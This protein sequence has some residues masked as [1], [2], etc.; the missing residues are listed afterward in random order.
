[1]GA[2]VAVA[3]SVCLAAA[4]QGGCAASSIPRPELPGGAPVELTDTSFHPQRDY[5]CGPAALA[6]VLESAGVAA[7]P[8]E[9]AP[10]LY[11]PGRRGSFQ[12]EMAALPR[13]YDRLAVPIEGSLDAVVDQLLRG[14]PVLVLQNLA[15]ERLPR[16]HYAV[17][18][19]Y[20]PEEDRFVLRSGDEQRMRVSRTRF[21]ATWLRAGRW[22][23]VVLPAG[24][25]PE[26]LDPLAYLRAAAGLETAG[27][28]GAALQAFDAAL[29]V[30]PDDPTARLGRANNLYQ[31]GRRDEAETAYRALLG[32]AP[33]DVAG[34]HNLAMLLVEDGRPCAA[35]AAL[36]AAAAGEPALI[37]GARQAALGATA[38][39]EGAAAACD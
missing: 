4:L 22:G 18:V 6:T 12:A 3:A 10:F 13:R 24:A 8:D 38:A 26:G 14:R 17:V 25:A 37:A 29:T 30:W 9:L 1:M 23:L 36:P 15:L 19:G 39:G 20:L 34:L 32:M 35:L 33:A 11:V 7:D 31:L 5:Q 2:L 21:L 28:Y 27:R 16:W